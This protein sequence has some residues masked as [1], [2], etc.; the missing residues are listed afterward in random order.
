ME[1]EMEASK[2]VVALSNINPE[3]YKKSGRVKCKLCGVTLRRYSKHLDDMVYH[4]HK[5]DCVYA[6]AVICVYGRELDPVAV[7]ACKGFDFYDPRYFV[8]HPPSESDA[9]DE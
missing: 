4:P 5:K 3:V 6:L 2:I 1:E 7:S 9:Q 8:L